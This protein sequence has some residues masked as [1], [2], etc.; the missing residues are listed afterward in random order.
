M[1]RFWYFIIPL[2]ILIA[3]E[4]IW[5]RRSRALTR[6]QRWPG[7]V[8]LLASGLVVM[9]LVAPAG[10]IGLSL[11]GQSQ[12]FGIFHWIDAPFWVMALMGY[13]LFDLAVWA[14]HVAMHRVDFLWRFHR[15][16]HADPDFDVV[17]AL[18]FHPGEILISLAWKGAIVVLLGVPAILVLWFEVILNVGAMF[19]HSN[20]K[21]PKP[22]DRWLRRLIV[23]PDM[24]RVHHSTDHVEANRN[25]GF[26]LP[27]WDRA[28]GLYQAQPKEGHSEMEIGQDD[29][30]T[31]QDQSIWALIIQP[32]YKP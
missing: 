24:H 5:P 19:N 30:R 27:W 22:V 26:F 32:R 16:H 23:T 28:F 11:W 21:L 4:A 9:R 7:A 18:R 25:F 2:L 31:A 3:L 10:L 14:Q 1:D 20:L 12:S 13:I 15:V 17:T 6:V 8:L 29:W